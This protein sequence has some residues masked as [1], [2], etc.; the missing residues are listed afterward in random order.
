[1][2]TMAN[3]ED[4]DEIPHKAAFHQGLH[5]L[6][7]YKQSSV[8][9]IHTFI[10]I[11]TCNPFKYKMANSI[12][13]VSICLVIIHKNKKGYA[14]YFE[15]LSPLITLTLDIRCICFTI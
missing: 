8:I 9:E 3:R 11:S 6:L 13:I 2:G 10:E 12:L 15:I 1:M 5:C 14:K 4:P 7:R